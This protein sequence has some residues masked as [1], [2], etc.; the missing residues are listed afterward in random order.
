MS[1]TT[2][3]P[4]SREKSGETKRQPHERF[5]RNIAPTKSSSAVEKEREMR[6]S[7]LTGGS[8]CLSFPQSN[9]VR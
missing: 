2:R 6:R 9:H 3:Q 8:Q 1:H 7:P 4:F 5:P